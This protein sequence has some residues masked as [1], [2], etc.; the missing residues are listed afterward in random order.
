MADHV[1]ESLGRP[2]VAAVDDDALLDQAGYREDPAYLRGG[3]ADDQVP[4]FTRRH[5]VGQDDH[6]NPGRIDEIAFLKADQDIDALPGSGVES[7]LKPVGDGEVE[8]P[9]EANL[10]AFRVQ[11]ALA[12]PKGAHFA[13]PGESAPASG[14]G[15]S[16]APAKARSARGGERCSADRLEAPGDLRLEDHN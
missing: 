14:T 7:L 11:V 3:M 2:R 15:R 6:R 8:L 10:A 9:L 16:R 4:T 5:S 13:P 12:D 1:S